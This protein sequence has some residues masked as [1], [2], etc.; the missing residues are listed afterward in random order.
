MDELEMKFQ[1]VLD[2]ATGSRM[3]KTSY[4][5]RDME[6]AITEEMDAIY[7][8][9]FED[10]KNYKKKRKDAYRDNG[11]FWV[12]TGFCGIKIPI[13]FDSEAMKSR[14]GDALDDCDFD[15]PGRAF[16]MEKE[17]YA[18][19]PIYLAD[20]GRDTALHETVHAVTYIMDH[21]GIEDDEFRA[22]VTAYLY[23]GVRK[24]VKRRRR[25]G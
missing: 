19:F 8:N 6:A 5:Y 20:L 15:T 4:S 16:F 7:N 3:S 24:A 18:E 2:F 9:G 14:Y 17:G 13:Y 21:F 25:D 23:K 11:V 1:K 12:E 22:Y 10:G